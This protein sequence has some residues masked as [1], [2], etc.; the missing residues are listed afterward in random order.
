MRG[1]AASAAPKGRNILA[2]GAAL[3]RERPSPRLRHPAG[4]GKGEREGAS[5]HGWEDVKKL[6]GADLKVCETRENAHLKVCASPASWDFFTASWATLCHPPELNS[7]AEFLN[8]LLTQD[9]RLL[10]APGFLL[11]LLAP[12]F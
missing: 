4:E 2:Q 10:L 7:G 9:T 5:T 6:A 8:E 12:C 11:L 1:S 3:E